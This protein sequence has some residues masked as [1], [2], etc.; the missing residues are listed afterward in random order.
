MATALQR[1]DSAA[2]SASDRLAVLSRLGFTPARPVPETTVDPVGRDGYRVDSRRPAMTT[3]VTVTVIHRSVACAEEGIGR[4]LEE[5]DRLIGIFN[6]YNDAS[7]LSVLNTHGRLDGPP[8]ELSTVISGAM[9][10]HRLSGG[11]FD[12]T[13]APLVN[14]LRACAEASV[15]REPTRAEV[16]EARACTGVDGI[17]VTRPSVRLVRAGMALTLDGIAKGYIVDRMAAT[18]ERAGV[19]RYLV[20]AG[21]DI[22]IGGSKDDG[23]PWTIAVRDPASDGPLPGTLQLSGGAV[24]TAGSY[25]RH[26][27]PARRFHHIVEP[28]SG[29]SPHECV[30]ATVVA[31]TATAADAL[32]TAV[33]VLGTSAGTALVERFPG[34]AS[35]VVRSDG[36]LF[37]SPGWRSSWT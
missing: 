30:S 11:A 26:F 18:L 28:T 4:A 23:L 36:R 2:A 25:E 22:R 17:A 33:L 6:R 8:P 14:L 21:G 13:V 31:P 5:M 37:H 7:A 32:A 20:E 1:P 15:P 9:A 16:Q 29:A 12:P 35:L 10:Y 34:C 3:L 27:D 24:A 19:D